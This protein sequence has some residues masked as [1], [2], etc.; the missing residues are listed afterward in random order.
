MVKIP[1]IK[2]P[3]CPGYQRRYDLGDYEQVKGLLHELKY[4]G[5][6]NSVMDW[7]LSKTDISN[8][9]LILAETMPNHGFQSK[10]QVAKWLKCQLSNCKNK[11]NFIQPFNLTYFIYGLVLGMV[12]MLMMIIVGLDIVTS[13]E[14]FT[15]NQR[16]AIQI[17]RKI[18]HFQLGID[19]I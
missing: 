3:N 1:Q 10:I 6:I 15:S 2:V 8:H 11:Q 7:L 19:T 13:T 4:S 14:L 9:S 18:G 12:I 16:T 17:A 5:K